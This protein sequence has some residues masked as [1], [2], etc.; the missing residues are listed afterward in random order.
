MCISITKTHTICRPTYKKLQQV[1]KQI[2]G[3]RAGRPGSIP[4]VGG[5]GDFSSFVR[6]QTGPEIHSASYKMSTGGFPR[7]VKAA[8]RRTSHPTSLQCRGCEYVVP[9]IHVP[10]GPSWPVMGIPLPFTKID[11]DK[12]QET[13]KQTWI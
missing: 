11:T 12:N 6:V 10:G 4:G 8:E 2:A 13:T 7:G 9:C 1:Q 3:V 5:G